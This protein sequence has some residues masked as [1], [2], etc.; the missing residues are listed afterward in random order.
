MLTYYMIVLVKKKYVTYY[1]ND[2][3]I[4]YILCT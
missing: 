3:N 2:T 4:C 1:G